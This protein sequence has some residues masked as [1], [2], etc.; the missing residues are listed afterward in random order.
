[1]GYTILQPNLFFQTLLAQ[2]PMIAK[3]SKMALPLAPDVSLS[4]IDTRDVGAVAANVL[5][6]DGHTGQTYY[7]S[8]A[9]SSLAAF[10]AELSSQLGKEIALMT[11]PAEAAAKMMTERGMPDWLVTHQIAMMKL[12]G[13]GGFGDVSDNVQNIAGK[14]PRTIANFIGDYLGA[15]QA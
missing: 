5:T 6:G 10:A 1:M 4:M 11:P 12:G 8:G 13:T 7:L 9:A 2:A 14:S 3:E 15:F